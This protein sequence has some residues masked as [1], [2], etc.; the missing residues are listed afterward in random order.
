MMS[1]DQFIKLAKSF[2]PK[3]ELERFASN[4]FKLF[5]EDKNGFLDFGEFSLAISAQVRIFLIS[6]LLAMCTSYILLPAI[7]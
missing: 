7:C 3:S 2:I 5:D 6:F 1:R 4:V